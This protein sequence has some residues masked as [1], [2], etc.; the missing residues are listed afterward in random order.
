MIGLQHV[1][2]LTPKVEVQGLRNENLLRWQ[3]VPES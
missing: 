1:I 2:G 3:S